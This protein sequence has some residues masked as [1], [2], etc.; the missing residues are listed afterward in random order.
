MYLPE[1]SS[2]R[3][4]RRSNKSKERDFFVSSLLG[5]FTFYTAMKKL[6]H[7]STST[8]LGLSLFWLEHIV[9]DGVE[10]HT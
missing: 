3:Q 2:H 4:R 9:D 5:F 1:F 6:S 10:K 8:L 7:I